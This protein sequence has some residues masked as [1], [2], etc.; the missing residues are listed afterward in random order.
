MK[1][2]LDMFA[3]MNTSI[4]IVVNLILQYKSLPLFYDCG[5]LTQVNHFIENTFLLTHTVLFFPSLKSFGQT[6][7][8]KID[9]GVTTLV[10]HVCC[11]HF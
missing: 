3:L 9:K 2:L 11:I 7:V 8:S 5:L 4:D 10:M 6:R 1:V